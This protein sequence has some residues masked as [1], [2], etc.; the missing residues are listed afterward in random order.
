V[1][2]FAPVLSSKNI[3]SCITSS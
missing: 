1:R 3:Y 2:T